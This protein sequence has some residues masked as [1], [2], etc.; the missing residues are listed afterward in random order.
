MALD[1]G[2]IIIAGDGS[3]SGSG[4]GLAIFNLGLQAIS[5]EDREAF[6]PGMK[7]YCEG[8][9]EAIIVH[10]QT[11]ADITTTITTATGALQTLASPVVALGDTLPPT[12][13]K[14]LTGTIV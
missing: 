7:P 10:F 9:A 11:N 4:L 13:D 3:V 12:A 14:V 5:V 8:L 1:I 2:E 6:A